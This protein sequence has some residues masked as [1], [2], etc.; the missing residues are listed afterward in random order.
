MDSREREA[1][2]R[3][4]LRARL[5]AAGAVLGVPVE[6]TEEAEW[7]LVD[8]TLRVGLG[9]YGTRGHGDTEAVA[10]A[11]LHLWE[12]PRSELTE[13]TRARRVRSIA[14]LRPE[15]EPLLRAVLRLQSAAELIAAF[16]GLREPLAV[17]LARGL[18]AEVRSLPRHLQWVTEILR[19]G[20]SAGIGDAGAVID[21]DPEVQHELTQLAARGDG[22]FDP[23]RRVLA[24]DPSRSALQRT[25]RALALLLP[26]Y[27]ALRARDAADRGLDVA[28]DGADPD[29]GDSGSALETG[30]GAAG[31]DASPGDAPDQS[32]A[33]PDAASADEQESARPG[34]G[35]DSA[36][37]ADLFAAEH[38]GFVE[39]ILNTP[40]PASGALLDGIVEQGLEAVAD[41]AHDDR[42]PGSAG[43]GDARGGSTALAAYR[44]RA[45]VL[46]PA[47]EAM[48]EVWSRVI[49]ERVARRPALSRRAE[50]EGDE[51]ATDALPAAIAEVLAG[52]A[53]PRAYR[54]RVSR[55]RPTRRA[56][57]TDYVF[58]IDRS[59]S[60]QGRIAAAA[61]DA[62]LILL[63][64]LSGV[65]RD[66]QHAERAL[67]SS[68][69]LDV[70]TA[71]LV[72][73]A[74]V[75]VVK[76]LSSGLDDAV[77]R[78]LDAAIRTPQG[79]TNDGAALRAAAE[80]LGAVGGEEGDGQQRR[81]IVFLMSDGGSNDP[82]AAARELRALRQLGVRVVGCGFGSDE[83][84][85]RY[86]PDGRRVDDPARLAETL[87]TVIVDE[88]P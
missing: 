73:D 33:A 19:R 6:V 43:G 7:E 85:N 34:E 41:A 52:V 42:D 29:P 5:H 69:E 4:E 51:L 22:S 39:S 47:I 9:W 38:A 74:E 14:A 78:R 71:L 50:P 53:R 16:P 31:A 72:F 44:S 21:V 13:A 81:R 12:G 87:S 18:P 88:L 83:M 28:G 36:E 45:A 80:Q 48:R 11:L 55:P 62:M 1:Q 61:S 59:A 40:M 60:M 20:G 24:P 57:N 49:A 54:R 77:R 66:V 76:P 35:S 23:L 8:G 3:G 58:L 82:V 68:L 67:G 79:S 17:A 2:R 65:E 30:A 63:E 46:A 26:S 37:G 10:L 64:A 56:G 84:T 75:E 70:R 25:E 86:A 32:D 27:D 15:T